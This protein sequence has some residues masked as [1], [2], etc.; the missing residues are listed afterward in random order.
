MYFVSG[1]AVHP[2]WV[3]FRVQSRFCFFS[4]AFYKPAAISIVPW[5]SPCVTLLC[6]FEQHPQALSLLCV[7][8]V[9]IN[10]CLRFS[11][12]K[13]PFPFKPETESFCPMLAC[14]AEHAS[15]TTQRHYKTRDF[16]MVKAIFLKLLK[17]IPS[18]WTNINLDSR[19][20]WLRFWWVKVKDQRSKSQWTHKTLQP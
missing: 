12:L 20:N 9:L 19:T 16:G 14:Q 1:G 10:L 13:L 2:F 7:N 18:V 6:C 8:F 11:L 3:L 17:R 15:H 5:E 4:F